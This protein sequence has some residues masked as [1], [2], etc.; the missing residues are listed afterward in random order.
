M[1]VE[2]RVVVAMLIALGVGAAGVHAFPSA[3]LFRRDRCRCAN[4]LSE[5]NFD[6]VD[7]QT[8]RVPQLLIESPPPSLCVGST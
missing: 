8:G 4:P 3:G 1:L 2:Q 6:R 7:G 5:T